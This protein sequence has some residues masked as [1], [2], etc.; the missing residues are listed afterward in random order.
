MNYLKKK[1]LNRYKKLIDSL[2][3]D[4]ERSGITDSHAIV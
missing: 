3:D 4:A 2:Y 1:D